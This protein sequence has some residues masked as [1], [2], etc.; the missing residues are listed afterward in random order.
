VRPT[1]QNIRATQ[2]LRRTR[3]HGIV[4]RVLRELTAQM[5]SANA[6]ISVTV[7]TGCKR[8]VPT[9]LHEPDPMPGRKIDAVVMRDVADHLGRAGVR[10]LGWSS[11]GDRLSV[12]A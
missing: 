2:A 1:A 5:S 11:R 12:A 7:K 4:S 3:A 6:P 8:R 9:L 10:V